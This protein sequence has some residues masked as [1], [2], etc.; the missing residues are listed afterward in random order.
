MVADGVTSY[1]QG[2]DSYFA[3]DKIISHLIILLLPTY[4]YVSRSEKMSF[5]E[6]VRALLITVSGAITL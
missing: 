6:L 3:Y 1:H 4:Y 5:K 2:F